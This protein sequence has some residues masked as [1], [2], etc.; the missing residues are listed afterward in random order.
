MSCVTEEETRKHILI[1]SA[2]HFQTLF[3]D[4]AEFAG[5]SFHTFHVKFVR[6]QSV[7]CLRLLKVETNHW[8]RDQM[9]EIK[10][11]HEKAHWVCSY[12]TVTVL[13]VNKIYTIITTFGGTRWSRLLRHCATSRKV[14]VSIP[15]GVIGTF[16]PS[17]RT[18][19]LELTQPLTE[20]STRYI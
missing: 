15:D 11:R 12:I 1:W 8:Y 20:N 2:V 16:H 10:E 4:F 17:G 5:R 19:A 18:M 14:A 3:W 6:R 13:G 7:V 9:G